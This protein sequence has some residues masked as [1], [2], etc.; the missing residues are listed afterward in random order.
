M[1]KGKFNLIGTTVILFVVFFLFINSKV[2]ISADQPTISPD[3]QTENKKKTMEI[4]NLLFGNSGIIKQVNDELMAKGYLFQTLIVAASVDE[5]QVKYVLTNK[6]AT[7]TEQEAVK[8][9]FFEIVKEN[10]LEPNAFK[11]KVADSDDGPDW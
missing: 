3:V 9:I 4:E 10:N 5:V 7:V 1:K 2:G 8:S 11:L 6:E